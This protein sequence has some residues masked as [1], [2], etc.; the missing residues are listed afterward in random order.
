MHDARRPLA[1]GVRA[2]GKDAV[3]GRLPWRTIWQLLDERGRTVLVGGAARAVVLGRSLPADVDLATALPV[4]EVC[5]LFPQARPTGLPF[6]TVTIPARDAL[7]QVT[8]FRR[9]TGY[10]DGRRP[11][12][13][14]FDASLV[15][16]LRRRDFTIG[17]F[18]LLLDGRVVDPF[19][20]VADLRRRR[21]VTV[22]DPTTRLGEDWLRLLRALR[23]VAVE[24]LTPD[25]LLVSVAEREA[26]RLDL[27]P[28]E[29]RFGE[30]RKA[31]LGV[32]VDRAWR[33]F[34]AVARAACPHLSPRAVADLPH[35]LLP[36][37]LRKARPGLIPWLRRAGLERQAVNL[38][39][40]AVHCPIWGDD[41]S[42]RRAMAEAGEPA[43]EL[44][45][46]VSG[47]RVAELYRRE[48]VLDV[49]RLALRPRDILAKTGLK[50]GP[51]CGALQ[52]H[53]MRL[54]W[55]DPTWNDMERLEEAAFSW[56]QIH[57]PGDGGVGGGPAGTL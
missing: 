56:L 18:A 53:L 11:S 13:V 46:L 45:A 6:G 35:A 51:W 28:V 26:E 30:L 20:G 19:G 48:G 8:T 32:A 12:R 16:D 10:K 40:R 47:G 5:R 23:F 24:D 42:L 7:V 29:R 33:L 52:R 43:T 27:L 55:R 36:R 31:L 38:L 44:R 9:E 14:T 54:V 21:L 49:R 3:G 2:V 4:D 39:E 15:E 57:H 17:A 41:F 37:L 50:P 34:P 1:S 22:G 25:P